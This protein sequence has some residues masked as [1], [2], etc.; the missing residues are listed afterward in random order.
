MIDAIVI[1]GG[2]N[3]LSAAIELANAGK[4]VWLYEANPTVG[5]SAR[6]AELTLPGFVHDICSA[7][8]PLA[9]GSPC[10]SRLPLDSY[11]L[12]YVYPPAALAHPFEDGSAILLTK[13]IEQTSAFFG[14]DRQPYKKL[15]SPI[16]ENWS[17]L[18]ADVLGPPRFPKHPLRAARFAWYAV[19]PAKALAS[20]IFKN[21]K[22]RAVFAGLAAHSCLA[23]EQ[24]GTSAFGL[25]LAA[26]A[27]A[28]GWPVA[29]CGSQSISNSLAAHLQ[30]LGGKIIT[31]HRVATLDELP[32]AKAILCDVTP[33][34]LICIAGGSFPQR[35]I[36]KLARYRYGAGVFKMDW[37][38]SERVPWKAKECFSAA[39]VHLG[40]SFDDV[41][42]SERQIIGGSYPE[43]PFTIVVQPTLFDESRAHSGRHTLWAYCHVPNGSTVDMSERMEKQIERFAPGFRDCILARSIMTTADLEA[44]NANLI[45]GD[46]GGGSADLLQLVLRP[47]SRW[48]ST[49]RKDLFLCSSSTPPGGGVHGLCGYYAARSAL[50]VGFGVGG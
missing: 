26:L 46:I 24:Y 3:G 20:T 8:H 15:I 36:R 41:L 37:A 34:Q 19:K 47:T 31:D 35:F 14:S 18:S 16:A 21:D 43:R 25:I 30:S 7:V 50:K 11:G 4:S 39:T 13:S 1:G 29:Q 40:S 44:H 9:A 10:F 17:E 33:R 2:P 42:L 5:G 45:G 49:P 6:S 48:Y 38:L 32:P 28:I 27:H 22:S 12:Q 23:L